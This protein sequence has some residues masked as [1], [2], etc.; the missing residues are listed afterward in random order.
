MNGA[1]GAITTTSK[2]NLNEKQMT[3]QNFIDAPM[4]DESFSKDAGSAK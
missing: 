2:F 1:A 4:E 3:A